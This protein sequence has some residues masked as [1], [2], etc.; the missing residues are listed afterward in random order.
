MGNHINTATDLTNNNKLM[1]MKQ[2]QL[3]NECKKLNIP[4]NGP[5]KDIVERII[6][7]QEIK[8]KDDEIL[9]LREQLKEITDKYDKLKMENN[10]LRKQNIFLVENQL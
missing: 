1:Q 2:S 4:H 3:V 5:K 8:S 9:H 6:N 10:F 7:K